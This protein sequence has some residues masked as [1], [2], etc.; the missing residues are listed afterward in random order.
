MLWNTK[1]D[2]R[3]DPTVGLETLAFGPNGGL[4]ARGS[5][6]ATVKPARKVAERCF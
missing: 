3:R 5:T 1:H 4:L 6:D 2:T